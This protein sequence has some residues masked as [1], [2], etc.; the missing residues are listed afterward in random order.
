MDRFVNH[1][2]L[3]ESL[4]AFALDAMDPEEADVVG[5][6]LDECPRCAEEVAQHQQVAALLG[7]TGGE[8]PAHLWDE[9]AEKIGQP[10]RSGKLRA[11]PGGSPGQPG[12]RVGGR[13]RGIVRRPWLLA[14]AAAVVAIALLS[15]RT[16]QLNDRVGSVSAQSA[17]QG[18]RSLARAAMADPSAKTVD[19]TSAGA[20]AAEVVVLPSGAAYLVNQTLPALPADETYQLWGRASSRLISLGVLGSDPTTVAF[21]VGPSADY[22]AYVVTAEPAGGV[23]KTSHRPVAASPPQSA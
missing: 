11:I 18:L 6:H 14:A 3:T 7:N 19:L 12:G 2:E 8:A 4:G 16:V 1:D 17:S 15:L 5:R 23:V 21:T 22:R 9:I 10:P 13:V 20:T